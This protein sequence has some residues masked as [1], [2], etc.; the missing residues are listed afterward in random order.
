MTTRIHYTQELPDGTNFVIVRESAAEIGH[1]L[2]NAKELGLASIY[3][4]K[5]HG[6]GA[7]V[8]PVGLV[9]PIEDR[10]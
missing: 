8:I 5:R 6:D 2:D 1:K 9:G 4:T 10:R 7:L 3:V